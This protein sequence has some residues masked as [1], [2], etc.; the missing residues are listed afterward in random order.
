MA[1]TL[2][3]GGMVLSLDADIGDLAIGDVLVENDKIVDVGPDILDH[4]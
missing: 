3:K 4:G 2:L 1:Q